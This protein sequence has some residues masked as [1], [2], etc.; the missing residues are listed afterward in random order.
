M[1]IGRRELLVGSAAASVAGFT[2][3]ARAAPTPI[4]IGAATPLSG[5]YADVGEQAKRA[6]M[7]GVD[8][9]NAAGGVDG[10]EV[11]VRFLDTEAK[12]DLTRQQ[13]EKLCLSGFNILT[14]TQTSGE[15]LAIAPM[16]A[17]W[18]AIYVATIAKA[19]AITGKSCVERMF[20]V[21]HPDISDAAVVRPWLASR[22]ETKW[23]I[24]AADMVW[25][26]D[27][28]ASFHAA[29]NATNKTIVS[30]NYSPF[31]TNDYA[32]YIQKIKDSGA[33]GLWVALSGGDAINFGRQAAQF[34]LLD[35]VVAAGVSF[36]TDNTVRAMGPIAKGIWNTINYSSTLDTPANKKFVE[37]WAKKYP[38]TAP[39]NFEGETY[40]GM[41]VIF[42]AVKKAR[43][44]EP[45]DLV[46]AMEGETFDTLF[47]P[48]L[49]RKEDHQLVVP[50]FFGQVGEVNGELRP[51][52]KMTVP[53][54]VATP[55]PDGSCHLAT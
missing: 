50:N 27:S 6:V 28:G 48:C 31:S 21:N 12:A 2:R 49:M 53:A 29:A 32:P 38:G 5:T 39:S 46:R 3:F 25:G 41:Q 11:Q 33:E 8:E 9:A 18:N 36:A 13:A 1:I 47:G 52:I 45:M 34:G 24:I 10:R 7:M 26:R 14:A 22:P 20:R 42:Q 54:D 17:R 15:S 51:I 35:H 16:L 40:I 23:A 30:E 37:A 4:R 55:P 43:S 19:N 44:V